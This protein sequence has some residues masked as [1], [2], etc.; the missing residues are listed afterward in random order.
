[1]ATKKPASKTALKD[2]TQHSPEKSIHSDVDGAS[3][4]VMHRKELKAAAYNPR[5]IDPISEK[6]LRES[7][8]RSG[9]LIQP[10]IWNKRTGTLV[11]GHRRLEQLDYIQKSDDYELTVAV[12][13]VSLDREVELNIALNNPSI[14]GQYDLDLLSQL[15]E[16]PDIDLAHTGFDVGTLEMMYLDA[17]ADLPSILLSPDEQES[18][19]AVSEIADEIEALSQEAESADAEEGNETDLDEIKN[20]KKEFAERQQFLHQNNTA[21]RVVFPTSGVRIFFA[22]TFDLDPNAEFLDGMQLLEKL[23]P[24]KYAE[25]LKVIESEKPQKAKKPVAEADAP[26]EKSPAKAGKTKAKPPANKNRKTEK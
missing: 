9:G 20:R 5:M 26:E 11:A 2:S 25:A 7:I 6:R 19:E 4:V 23:D 8:Q 15:L 14:G 21:F 18:Q 12:I 16:R 10:P 17:G 22:E 13:D 24:D 3:Y 1:M